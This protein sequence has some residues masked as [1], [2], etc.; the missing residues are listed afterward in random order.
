METTHG[1]QLRD[2]IVCVNRTIQYRSHAGA[3]WI[4]RLADSITTKSAA[5]R[6]GGLHLPLICHRGLHAIEHNQKAIPHRLGAR[7]L[8]PPTWCASEV[9]PINA[10]S[11]ASLLALH[12]AAAEPPL[13]QA[14]RA[15]RP[16]SVAG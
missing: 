16:R 15:R 13:A 2:V 7:P 14:G 1:H 10:T 11:H 12:H 4:A 5:A 9:G 6:T 8:S 3:Y